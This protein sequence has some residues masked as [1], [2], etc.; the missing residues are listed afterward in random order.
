[1][2]KKSKN[3]PVIRLRLDWKVG[4]EHLP[5]LYLKYLIDRKKRK[6]GFN[7]K[8]LEGTGSP[9]SIRAVE[10][11]LCDVALC[12]S[13]TFVEHFEEANQN[14]MSVALFIK[15]T[16]IVI[17][18]DRQGYQKK[19]LK[20]KNGRITDSVLAHLLN[21]KKIGVFP[22][23]A[24]RDWLRCFAN[25]LDVKPNSIV[26][27]SHVSEFGTKMFHNVPLF[28][29]YEYNQAI[30]IL[31][32]KD[33]DDRFCKILVREKQD[34]DEQNEFE[35]INLCST[36]KIDYSKMLG[37]AFIANC[38]K[39][40]NPKFKT[41]LANLFKAIESSC[42]EIL[43]KLNVDDDDLEYEIQKIVKTVKMVKGDDWTYVPADSHTLLKR[44]RLLRDVYWRISLSKGNSFYG[45]R[46]A[47]K[48]CNYSESHAR[49]ATWPQ[50]GPYYRC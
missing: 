17:I 36:K 41:S 13:V 18:A 12:G 39:L 4:E 40:N 7:L 49:L 26:E 32:R 30:E 21:G 14:P 15:K 9:D 34:S 29:C 35:S 25:R 44:V 45:W 20:V 10:N 43:N 42:A 50:T 31:C 27:I 23:S 46:H 2:E 5:L 33:A 47:F 6:Y 1:M 28:V 37:V 11:N 38:M 8:I 16:P 3:I 48:Y 22:S 19:L 24:A